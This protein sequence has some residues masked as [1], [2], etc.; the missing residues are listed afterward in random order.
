[1][2]YLLLFLSGV[3]TSIPMLIPELWFIAFFTMIPFIYILNKKTGQYD[4]SIFERNSNA[5]ENNKFVR[6]LGDVFSAEIVRK[7]KAYLYGLAFGAGYYGVLYSWFTYLYPLD[8]LGFGAIKSILAI[9]V[10][11]GGLTLLQS[12]QLAFVPLCYRLLKPQKI[13]ARVLTFASLWV[14]LEWLQTQTWLGVPWGRLALTQYKNIAGIQSASLFGSMFISFIIAAVNALL[15]EF[16]NAVLQKQTRI[17]KAALAL[18]AV[19]IVLANEIFGYVRLT[20]SDFDTGEAVRVAMLQGNIKSNE[21]WD[22]N[23]AETIVA[24]HISMTREAAEKYDADLIVWTETVIP[25]V[26]NWHPELINQFQKLAIETKTT[27]LTGAFYEQ[28]NVSGFENGVYN[29]VI[30]FYPDGSYDESPYFKRHLVPF[31]EYVPMKKL[32]SLLLPVLSDMNAFGNDLLPGKDTEIIETDYG[33]IGA[34]V[35]FD[36][37]YEMLTVESVR[38]GAE[39]ITILTNDSW[40]LDSAAVWQ[41][42]AHAVMRAVENGRYVVR[43]ANTGVS[44]VISPTGDIK[45]SLPALVEGILCEDVYFTDCETMYTRVGNIIVT[46]S[47]LF[48]LFEIA[49]HIVEARNYKK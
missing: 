21:K 1:M 40:Y 5:G 11:W 18:S 46:V 47:A 14:M 26:L 41:H 33:K 9:F 37:I 25:V 39:L 3:C 15:A 23:M 34:L 27:I 42:N 44:S 17:K 7:K 4:A 13:T 2:I 48:L 43:A 24:Q 30:T 28:E 6:L 20:I 8:F 16:L 22:D 29:A 12:L 35:C 49:R 10:C 32:I 38:D 31:G 45:C 36:S 19:I